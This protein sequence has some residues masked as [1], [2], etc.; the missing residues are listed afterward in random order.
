MTQVKEF[1][2]QYD[3]PI[4]TLNNIII[5]KLTTCYVIRIFLIVIILTVYIF[6]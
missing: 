6:Y 3:L 2:W 4:A 1:M 5:K